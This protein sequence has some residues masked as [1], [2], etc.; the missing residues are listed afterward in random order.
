V[1][2]SLPSRR[3]ILLAALAL[4]ASAGL[5]ASPAFAASSPADP[6]AAIYRR[7]TAGK[8]T[9]G[10]Q[11][12]WAHARARQ[13]YMSASLAKLWAAAL[14]RVKP[15]DMGPPGFDPV[16][17]SQDPLVRAFAVRIEKEDGARATVAVTFGTK[18]GALA[19]QPTQIVRYDMVRERGAWRIDDIRG[20][21]EGDPWSIRGILLGF[22]G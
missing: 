9:E 13:R 18:P 5:P 12:V 19:G 22:T 11:F 21:V 16:S 7:V 17:N 8:G 10:G 4:A 1:N 6:I 15:G 2:P 20:S 14:A 3:T